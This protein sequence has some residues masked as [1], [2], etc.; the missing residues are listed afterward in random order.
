MNKTIDITGL[1]VRVCQNVWEKINGWCTSTNLEC[2]GFGLVRRKGS[3]FTI[4]DAFLPSQVCTPG[5]TTG[6]TS[7]LSDIAMSLFKRGIPTEHLK[8]WWHTHAT[9]GCFWSGTDDDTAKRLSNNADGYGISIVT[10]H[11]NEYKA[12]IDA[13]YPFQFTLDDIELEFI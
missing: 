4:Y 6:D 7:G 2:S 13:T 12:R 1:K 8:L 10:N 11:K 5:H 3:M 9:F